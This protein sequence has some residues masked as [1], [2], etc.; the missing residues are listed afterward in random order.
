MTELL[1]DY[2]Y[3]LPEH[4][5]AHTPNPDKSLDRLMV[6]SKA[7]ETLAEST[8]SHKTIDDLKDLLLPS[9]ILVFN[10]TK[11]IPAR[12][13]ATRQTG[14][15]CEVLLLEEEQPG[16]WIAMIKNVRK[17]RKDESL[18]L[19]GD[20]QLKLVD[21]QVQPGRHR[22]QFDPPEDVLSYL[23][24]WG[25]LPL[26]PYVS[27]EDNIDLL[28]ENYQTAFAEKPGAVAAPTAGLHFTEDVTKEL[29]EKGIRFETI[30]LHVGYGTFK[31]IEA[32]NITNH[33]MH[34]EQYHISQPTADRLNK[35]LSDGRRI[36]AVGTTVTRTLES[37][38]KEKTLQSGWGK[39]RLFI[40]PGYTF[41][42]ISGL[43]TNFHLPKSTLLCLVS[44]LAG[45]DKIKAAYQ[46]A[47]ALSYRFFSFGDAM[48]I[49]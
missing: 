13:Q 41:N 47:I 46:E 20:R 38:V 34:E 4:L 15:Q 25:S 49:I 27:P 42:V 40:Y 39:T 26:P 14:G 12:L 30:T 44:A 33:P 2:N 36:I 23:D 1:R 9:D 16:T 31:P 24:D 43:I 21:K 19:P 22:V 32:Q 35:A 37:A 45:K 7:T 11:V 17:L 10:D 28:E 3:A 29:A 8:I 18:M 5:I 48:L 6:L